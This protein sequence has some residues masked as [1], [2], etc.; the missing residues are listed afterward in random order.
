MTG[1][2]LALW[3]SAQTPKFELGEITRL[4]YADRYAVV[5]A[6]EWTPECGFEYTVVPAELIYPNGTPKK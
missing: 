4:S 6:R 1:L 5:I 2:F 3:L